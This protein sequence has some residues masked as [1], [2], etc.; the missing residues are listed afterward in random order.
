MEQQS[1]VQEQSV[2]KINFSPADCQ[3]FAEDCRKLLNDGAIEIV[4][5]VIKY[6]YPSTGTSDYA[7]FLWGKFNDTPGG[8]SE[9]I[10]ACPKP[11]PKVT[12]P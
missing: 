2:V 8:I 3:K 10:V 5:E 9:K 7:I 1:I 12:T 11:C 6:T 4:T